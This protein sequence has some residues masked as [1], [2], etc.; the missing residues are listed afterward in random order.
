M[1]SDRKPS[2]LRA[3]DQNAIRGDATHPNRF[4]WPPSLLALLGRVTDT[5]IARRAGVSR[6]TVE[7]ER[8]RRGI[9][10]FTPKQTPV[11]WTPALIALLGQVTDTQLADDLGVNPHTV[12]AKRRTLGIP[13]YGTPSRTA[14]E[15]TKAAIGLLG[16]VSDAEVGRALGIGRNT[17]RLKR[18]ELGIASRGKA[19]VRWTR[20]MRSLLG[21]V[22]DTE[23]AVRYG[24]SAAAVSAE[25]RR[26]K[27]TPASPKLA[28]VRGPELK[29]LLAAHTAT[30]L[31]ELYRIGYATTAQLRAELGIPAPRRKRRQARRDSPYFWTAEENALL[32]KL[33]D[34]D[35]AARVGVTP[36]AAKRKRLVL[37]IPA[38]PSG[39]HRWTAY[40]LEIL[41]K[42]PDRDVAARVGVSVKA[43]RLRRRRLGRRPPK[44]RKRAF[45]K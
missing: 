27:I 21:R 24:I 37:R 31:N 33:S 12:Y 16:K 20:K 41:G 35:V 15:W 29:R 8:Q 11:R 40:Q 17:V 3:P 22:A 39:Y 23:V 44:A 26:L 19:P 30:E 6:K 14:Y 7:A 13:P 10:A 28:L 9:P 5:A 1:L 2:T 45:T 42:L 38:A 18:R 34:R 32:G 25:R 4:P 43:V 36:E